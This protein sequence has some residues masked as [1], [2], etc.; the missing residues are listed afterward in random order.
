[1]PSSC[2][3]GCL[4]AAFTVNVKSD[5]I[6]LL[7]CPYIIVQTLSQHDVSDLL[8][9]CFPSKVSLFCSLAWKSGSVLSLCTV[10]WINAHSGAGYFSSSQPGTAWLFDK[11]RLDSRIVSSSFPPLMCIFSETRKKLFSIVFTML[12]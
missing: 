11:N 3:L 8:S 7:Y 4:C 12:T 9:R 5:V 10:W 2:S 6:I 1:M